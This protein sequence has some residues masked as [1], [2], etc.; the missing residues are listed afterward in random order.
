MDA[1]DG[2]KNSSNDGICAWSQSNSPCPK[3]H[4]RG[5]DKFS[6]YKP[7]EN[8]LTQW[9]KLPSPVMRQINTMPPD[10]MQTEGHSITSVILLPAETNYDESLNSTPNQVTFYKMVCNI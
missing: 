6:V 3:Y 4:K 9:S 8:H 10:K 5:N 1:K 7:W 2:A